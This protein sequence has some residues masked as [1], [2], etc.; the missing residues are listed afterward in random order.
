M[1]MKELVQRIARALVDFPQ[2]LDVREI[3]GIS[4][5]LLEIKVSKQDMGYLIGRK[6]KKID[7]LRQIVSAA[8]KGRHYTVEVLLEGSS[9]AK[10]ICKGRIGSLLEDR[11]YGYIEGDDGSRVFFHGSSLREVEIGSLSSGQQVEFEIE[12]SPKGFKVV[13]IVRPTGEGS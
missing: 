11:N 1:E 4:A 10:G 8:G 2:E 7:P 3:S 9:K 12:E 6:G 5:T 13:S